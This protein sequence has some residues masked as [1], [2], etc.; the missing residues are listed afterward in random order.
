MKAYRRLRAGAAHAHG[1]LFAVAVRL[2]LKAER[3]ALSGWCAVTRES[4]YVHK[5]VLPASVGHDEAKDAFGVPFFQ[6][7]LVADVFLLRCA[8]L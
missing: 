8:V 4:G 6:R 2:Y 5:D 3:F 7:A 1:F